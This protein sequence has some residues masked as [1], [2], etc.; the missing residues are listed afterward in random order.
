MEEIVNIVRE[1][2]RQQGENVYFRAC[3]TL[4]KHLQDKTQQ[5]SEELIHLHQSGDFG[6]SDDEFYPVY[7]IA[8]EL[9]ASVHNLTDQARKAQLACEEFC[10]LDSR[11]SACETFKFADRVQAPRKVVKHAYQG[12]CDSPRSMQFI[13][14]PV[15]DPLGDCTIASKSMSEFLQHS[16]I[17]DSSKDQARRP[18]GSSTS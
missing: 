3:Y 9:Q 15:D 2:G 8:Q 10:E 17:P 13:M 12:V 4:F 5:A 11:Y 18:T 7:Q 14:V 16:R 6:S 1:I